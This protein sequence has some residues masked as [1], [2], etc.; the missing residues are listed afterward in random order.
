VAALYYGIYLQVHSQF[1]TGRVLS[2]KNIVSM[3]LGGNALTD[4]LITGS[5][6]FHLGRL[7]R[8]G[9]LDGDA[10]TRI[11]RLPIE[12]NLLTTTVGIVSL[13][14][15]LIYPKKEWFACPLAILGKLYS[16]TLLVSLNNRNSIREERGAE[17]R[18]QVVTF[19]LSPDSG[20]AAETVQVGKRPSVAGSFA[21]SV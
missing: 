6:L 11:V 9:L 13:V 20:P 4:I 3:W 16:N 15:V 14:M 10:L 19:G 21:D 7:R 12:T 18:S 17:A 8:D 5:M 1:P 2:F